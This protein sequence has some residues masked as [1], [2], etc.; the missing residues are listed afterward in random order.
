[1]SKILIIGGVAGG[2]SAAA[3]LRRL[4]EKA[5][6]TVFE[7]GDYISYANCG[8]PYYIGGVI[9][10]RDKLFVQT[11]AALQKRF[12]INVRTRHE[13]QSI[14]RKNKSAHIKNLNG[15]NEFDEPYDKLVL[16]PGAEPFRPDIP[17]AD[18]PLIYTLR[19]ISDTDR[20]KEAAV[21]N[22][23][24]RVIIAGG[25]YI[26]LEMA[27]NFRIR[28]ISVVIAEMADQ[29]L[30]PFDYEMAALV[31]QH[32]RAKG[33]EF[34]LN[35]AAE[36]FK[37]Y[38]K[39]ISVHLKSGREIS[40]DMLILSIGVK[41]DTRLAKSA[42]IETGKTGG[43][44][45]NAYMQTSD[46]DIY[47]AG[48]A[49]EVYHPVLKEHVLLPLAGPANK[50]GRI[51]ADNIINGNKTAYRG[52][53]GT[54]IAKI[55]DLTAAVTGA[56]EKALK[57]ANIPC[58]SVIVHPLSHAGYYPG[59]LTLS[60]KVVFSPEDGRILGAQAVGCEGVDKRIDAI[61]A[62]I[63]K[64][65][66]V[67]D[68]LELEHAY[69]PPYSSAKDPVNMAG[70][71]AENTLTGKM[72]PVYWNEIDALDKKKNFLLDVRTPEEFKLGTIP[73]AVNI[74]VD[75]LREKLDEIPKDKNIAVFCRVGF[76]GYIAARILMQNEFKNVTNLSGGYLTYSTAKERQDNPVPAG[77]S[78]E[79][80]EAGMANHK[81][82]SI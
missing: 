75:S 33:I 31:H 80:L 37:E 22:N 9:N 81:P 43:I 17:G 27:E 20:I 76:R 21:K 47:A 62:L 58:L 32:L 48:D 15:G 41:P 23:P 34:Y 10:D 60:L 82:G 39:K 11:P 3:R 2:M 45:V 69:A 54:A 61:A 55:F 46:P 66:T 52:S 30:T 68:L 79:E 40:A 16:S 57:K 53:I 18:S 56:S 4:D 35:D 42:G 59:A 65:G 71:T 72:K 49:V 7:R 6:I 28:G 8:L 67:T 70:F 25:G 63:Q 29:I 51:A 74:S 77:T 44:K 78:G 13:V 38:N 19:N 64:D 36:S 24:R 12:N 5:E 1:M 26:G 50:Q 14:D 73:G